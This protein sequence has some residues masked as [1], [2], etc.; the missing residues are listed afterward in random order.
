MFV[1]I[2]AFS[3]GGYVGRGDNHSLESL[4]WIK[5][6]QEHELG[7]ASV[8]TALSDEGEYRI[9]NFR[10]DGFSSANGGTVLEYYGCRF[11]DFQGTSHTQIF[12]MWTIS[13]CDT[14]AK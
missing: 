2:L 9:E 5:Y 12:L 10:V 1:C 7:G 13:D 11:V 14:N 4:Q 8:Q 6:V 3:A